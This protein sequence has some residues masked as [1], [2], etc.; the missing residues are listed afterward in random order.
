VPSASAACS[1]FMYAATER[2]ATRDPRPATGE[3]HLHIMSFGLA[4]GKELDISGFGFLAR[5]LPPFDEG[6]ID[7]RAWFGQTAVSQPFHL[8]I[9]SGKGTFLVQQAPLTPETNY[10]GIEWAGEFFRYAADRIRRHGLSNV[11]MLH[12]D[13]AEFIRYW[14]ADSLCD[15]VHLYF[16]DPWPKKKHHKRRFIQETMLVEFHR[17]LKLGGEVRIVTDHDDY[18][19]WMVEHFERATHLFD[20]LDF[21]RR[22]TGSDEHEVVGTNFERKYRREGRPFHATRLGRRDVSS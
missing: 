20:R 5:D 8:E 12:G 22:D 7:P 2:P 14:L 11:R 9:G 3:Y 1:R 19:S 4:R 17:I 13:A 18:W 15:V 6:R 21:D 10:L 16:P